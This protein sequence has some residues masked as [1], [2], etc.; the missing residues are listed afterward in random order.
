MLPDLHAY[1]KF[2]MLSHARVRYFEAGEGESLLLLHGMGLNASADSFQFMFETLAQNYHVIALDFPGFGKSDRI[3]K[4]G[5]T[6]DVIVDSVRE[7]IDR[8]ALEKPN[9][10]AH[11]AGGWFASILAY[12]S[13]DRLG[14][15]ILIGTAGLNIAPAAVASTQAAPDLDSLT[16]AN[17]NSVY[18]GSV[19]TAA[20]AEAVAAQMLEY[21]SMPGALDS[22]KPLKAQM[23]NPDIRALYLLQRRLPHIKNPILMIWGSEDGM[24]PFPTWT[25]EWTS[26]AHDPGMGSKPWVAPDMQF[27]LIPGATHFAH[28][29][30]PD[31]I[32]EL[33]NNFIKS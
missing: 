22:L 9:V 18:E 16:Q 21:V 10:L 1:E 31:Q 28:W 3:L 7:L 6:F 23:S 8:K 20:M 17:M 11:S 25:E 29:E 32:I 27:A 30:H 33:V 5:P 14:K 24:E 12:E 4:H 15:L 13:P 26:S 2:E 19:F